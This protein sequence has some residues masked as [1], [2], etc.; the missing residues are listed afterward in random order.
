MYEKTKYTAHPTDEKGKVAYTAEENAIWQELFQRQQKIVQNRACQAYLEGLSLLQLPSDRIPQCD[1][2]SERLRQISNWCVV[3]V[4]ALISADEFFTLLSQRKFPAASFIRLRE[5]IDYLE[6]PD[7]FHEIFGHCPLLTEPVYAD[8]MQEYGKFALQASEEDRH[9]LARLYWFT[10]EF[11]LIHTEEGLRIYGGGILSSKNETI[12]ALEAP[13]AKRLPFSGLAA[14]RT[15]YRI[16][17][18]QP[19]YFVI[20]DFQTLYNLLEHDI[21]GLIEQARQLGEYPPLFPGNN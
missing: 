16:D 10:V 13:H 3:P 15:P 1:E 8:F 7:I 11:G 14:L 5:E 17:I 2:V 21:A 18:M 9:F 6:E 4:P 12:Y 19:V 20:E